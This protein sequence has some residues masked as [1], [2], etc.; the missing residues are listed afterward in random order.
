M[1]PVQKKVF[2]KG[3]EIELQI[4]YIIVTIRKKG[5]VLIHLHALRFQCLIHPTLGF[6]IIVIHEANAFG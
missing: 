2:R 6:G 4:S 3:V 1:E 5:D